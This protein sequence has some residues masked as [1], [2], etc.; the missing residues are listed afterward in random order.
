MS[1]SPFSYMIIHYLLHNTYLD[2]RIY[3]ACGLK[4]VEGACPLTCNPEHPPLGKYVYGLL[5]WISMSALRAFL[6]VGYVS[7][8]ALSYY[9]ASRLS[10]RRGGI[11]AA[12][13]LSVDPL[14]ANVWGAALLDNVSTLL[15][16]A[17]EA[18]FIS[19]LTR[20]SR[21]PRERSGGRRGS[22][23]YTLA[24]GLVLA[25]A[26]YAKYI[27]AFYVL[28]LLVV[29]IAAHLR[30]RRVGGDPRV[31]W[32][33]ASYL[34]ASIVFTIALAPIVYSA[35]LLRA[36]S[37]GELESI[38]DGLVASLRYHE[39]LH[40][41]RA[42][43]AAISSLKIF[44]G[45]EVWRLYKVNFTVVPNSS[46][47]V[48]S[49]PVRAG[50]LVFMNLGEYSPY[51]A[52]VLVLAAPLL[53]RI[54]GSKTLDEPESLGR[55]LALVNVYAFLLLG[56]LEPIAWYYLPLHYM[57]AIAAP[58]VLGR[59]GRYH[60]LILALAYYVLALALSFTLGNVKLLATL[61]S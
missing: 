29:V 42:A 31:S 17:S 7:S 25:L 48:A 13:L 22:R 12:A 9:V 3:I 59:R 33:V 11:L 30:G 24:A 23:A 34:I 2:E 37:V 19:L 40:G 26:F 28:S 55:L 20:L 43:M 58:V 46:E 1:V 10:D 49:T 14:V 16:L 6:L 45:V 52:V 56:L 61:S 18:L 8:I 4:Y 32:G 54:L 21:H 53:W 57:S 39:R 35:C 51:V 36:H 27:A 41:P 5:A 38:A 47:V 44:A 15:I 60:L 50:W